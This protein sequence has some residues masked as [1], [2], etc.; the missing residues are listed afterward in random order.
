VAIFRVSRNVQ[1]RELEATVN[2]HLIIGAM[3]TSLAFVHRT[4]Y[5]GCAQTP[6]EQTE[7]YASSVLQ[8]TTFATRK[9][10]QVL[11]QTTCL[12]RL[13]SSW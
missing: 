9:K 5:Q 1:K 11:G 4:S 6:T 2:N 8:P 7:F 10:I 13:D 12:P 3:P